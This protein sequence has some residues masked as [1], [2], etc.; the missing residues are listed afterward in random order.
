MVITRVG[1]VSMCM[2]M[3]R[4]AVVF[5][6]GRAVCGARAW[7][8]PKCGARGAASGVSGSAAAGKP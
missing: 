8:R 7:R 5:S 6:G 1:T 3:S 2:S 4:V